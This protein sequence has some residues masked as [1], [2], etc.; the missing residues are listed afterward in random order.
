MKFI[1][2]IIIT[3]LLAAPLS[4][5]AQ[6]LYPA[7]NKKDKWGYLNENGDKVIDYKYDEANNFSNGIAIVK[8]GDNLGVIGTNGKEIIPIKYNLIEKHN[9]RIFRVAANG[10]VKDGVLMDEKYGFV[11]VDGKVLLKPEY[12]EIGQFKNGLA[13]IKK[14]NLYGY[15]NDN[16]DVIIPCKF[17]AVGAFNKNGHVWVAQG[18]KFDKG[19]TSKFSGGKLGVYDN[20]GKVIIEPKYSY[21]GYYKPFVYEPSQEYLKSLNYYEKKTVEESGSHHFNKRYHILQQNL[22]AMPDTVIGYYA[23]S[24]NNSNAVFSPDGKQ[25]FKDGL[26]KNATLYYPSD[27]FAVIQYNGKKNSSTYN[28]LDMSN[29]FKPLFSKPVNDVWA[30]NNGVAV[31]TRDGKKWELIDTSGN[32]VS[33]AYTKIYPEKDGLFIVKS[34]ADPKYYYY[35]AI[36]K[37]GREVIPATHTFILPPSHGLIACKN[38]LDKKAGYKDTSGKWVIEDDFVDVR[39]FADGLAPV[40]TESGWGVITPDGKQAVKCQWTDIITLGAGKHGFVWVTDDTDDNK[41]FKML[42]VSDEKEMYPEKFYWLRT[43]GSD[44]DDVALVGSDKDNIGVINKEGKMLVP[45]NFTFD[46]AKTAYK[47]LLY[48]PG[49]EWTEFDTYRVKLYSNPN[50]NKGRLTSKLSSNLWDY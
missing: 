39:S 11:D 35:G 50:R 36:N 34:D 44:F 3:C 40:K 20:T 38:A 48:Y 22:T 5:G 7:K 28:F 30:F 21:L 26:Y 37:S 1:N 31:I 10:K 13:F 2:H 33:A 14:G 29:N 47:Y 24:G 16:I 43:F 46:Q 12:E 9:D 8:K 19:S 45:A 23:G 41:G 42:R 4:A 32:S 49:K 6:D 27:G 18:V 15:I 17:N 25:I